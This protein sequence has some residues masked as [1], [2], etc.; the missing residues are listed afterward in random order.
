MI[1]FPELYRRTHVERLANI[2][3]KTAAENDENLI[4][5]VIQNVYIHPSANVHSSATVILRNCSHNDSAI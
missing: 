4:C 5:N 2:G 1:S 3:S